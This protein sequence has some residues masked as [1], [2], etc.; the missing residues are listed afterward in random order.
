[1]LNVIRLSFTKLGCLCF[2]CASGW[3]ILALVKPRM[4]RCSSTGSIGSTTSVTV[5]SPSTLSGTTAITAAI[6]HYLLLNIKV[7]KNHDG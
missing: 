1:M 3:K 7:E 2:C 4:C 5:S 6:F